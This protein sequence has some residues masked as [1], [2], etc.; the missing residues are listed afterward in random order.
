MAKNVMSGELIGPSSE[1]TT[2][3]LTERRIKVPS[4][5]A[6]RYPEISAAL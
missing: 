3:I 6:S 1:S 2:I 5:F 4:T